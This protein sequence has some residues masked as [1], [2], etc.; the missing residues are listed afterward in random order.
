MEAKDLPLVVVP[1]PVWVNEMGE[2]RIRARYSYGAASHDRKI[3]RL[4]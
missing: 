3:K 4:K 2:V 1:L